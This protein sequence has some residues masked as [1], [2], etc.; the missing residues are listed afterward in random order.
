MKLW[1]VLHEPNWGK[2]FSLYLWLKDGGLE[3]E[4]DFNGGIIYVF[5]D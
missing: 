2:A 1:K 3:V 4:Y 5:R